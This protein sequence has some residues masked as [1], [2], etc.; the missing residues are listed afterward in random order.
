MKL[1]PNYKRNA[2]G[3]IGT[4]H[5]VVGTGF[6]RV[7]ESTEIPPNSL[8]MY[9]G[10]PPTHAANSGVITDE[11]KGILL[12]ETRHNYTRSTIIATALP[13]PRHSDAS[14]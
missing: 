5:T 11:F 3:N 6:D 1:A 13:P 10:L 2:S 9:A 12:A 14:P 7:T 8:L 4:K